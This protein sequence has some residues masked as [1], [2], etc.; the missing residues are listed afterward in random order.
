ME[1]KRKAEA[2]RARRKQ[3]RDDGANDPPQLLDVE[4]EAL[5]VERET[6]D[7]SN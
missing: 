1:K 4:T 5:N 3:M 2:K 7:E 6:P